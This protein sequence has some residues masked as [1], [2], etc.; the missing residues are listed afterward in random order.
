MTDVIFSV[1]TIIVA[2]TFAIIVYYIYSLKFNQKPLKINTFDG[3]NSPYHPSVL[4][5]E[6]GWNNYR[7]WMAETPFSPKCKPYQDRNE[8]PSIHVSQDGIRWTEI[9]KNP[10]V[11][12]DDEGVRNLNFYSDPHLVY[13]KDR[14]ECWFRLTERQGNRNL[15]EVCSLWRIVSYDGI[16]WGKKEKLSQMNENVKSKGL[17]QVLVSHAVLW[18]DISQQYKIWYVDSESHIKKENGGARNIAYSC[19]KDAIKW[20]DKIIVELDKDVVNPWHI[21]VYKAIDGIYYLTIY[22]D[23]NNLTLWQ[24]CDG[25]RFRYM[26]EVLSPSKRIGSYYSNNL[27]RACL[28]QDLSGWKM[29][30]SADDYFQTHIGVMQGEDIDSL[31]VISSEKGTYSSPVYIPIWYIKRKMISVRFV[32]RHYS[33]YLKK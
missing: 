5:F 11:D 15:Y 21:D 22:W 8:C 2:V 29:Y 3:M 7:Y 20:D 25:I 18:D 31:R 24:S 16:N 10:I 1:Y 14:I 19:S 30:F 23:F 28:L 4:Y 9:C 33:N 13:C 12:L 32:L 6:K 27:Y 26:R 17:G